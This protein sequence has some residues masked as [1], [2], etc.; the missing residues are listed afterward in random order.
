[1]KSPDE[2]STMSTKRNLNNP[3][4]NAG[5]A[6]NSKPNKGTATAKPK[7]KAADQ[8]FKEAKEKHEEYAR[9]HN[10]AEYDSSSDEDLETGSMLGN[11]CLQL[12]TRFSQLK[13][14]CYRIR[15]QE[16]RR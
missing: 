15:F 14:P 10:I 13:C 8:K 2:A 11:G 3:W 7:N 12:S 1:M 9:K 5:N 16:L 6:A 4:N